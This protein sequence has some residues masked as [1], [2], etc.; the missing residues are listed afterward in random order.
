MVSII[1]HLEQVSEACEDVCCDGGNV[2]YTLTV[3]QKHP[4]QQQHR[5]IREQR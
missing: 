5:P 4:D 2:A 1:T 3:F